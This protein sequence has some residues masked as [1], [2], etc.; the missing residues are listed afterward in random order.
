MNR[1]R[2]SLLAGGACA[3]AAVA[4]TAAAQEGRSRRVLHEELRPPP[5]QAARTAARLED[6]VPI[7][8][9]DP[10]PRQ[11]PSAVAARDKILPEPAAE[12]SPSA[13]E[14]VHGGDDFGAVRQNEAR[15]DYM[16]GADGTLHYVEVFNPSVV[17]FKR[18]SAL[19]SVREDYTLFAGSPA[20][21]DVAVGGAPSEDRD[22]FW[23][24]LVVELAPG[25]DVPIPSV[26][27]DMRILS[28]EVEPAT[29]VTFSR[30]GSDNFYVRSDETG[31]AGV[32][33]L[34][35]LAD[36]DPRYF[37]PTVPERLR[38]RDV[39]SDRVAPLPPRVRLTAERALRELGVDRGMRVSEALERLTY[40]FRDFSPKAP[41]RA[42]GDVY[43]DLFSSR[44][45]VC[46]HRS[47]AFMITAN[48]LGLPTRYLTNEAHAWVEVWLPEAGWMRVDLGGAAQTLQ[49]QNARDK[50]MY[51]PR[52]DDPFAKPPSYAE[53]Y[54]RLEGDVEGLSD[55][56]IAERQAPYAA[57][58][59]GDGAGDDAFEDAA[60]PAAD[61]SASGTPVAPGAG[62]PEVPEE[63]L[64]GKQ[65]TRTIVRTASSEGYRGESITIEG[66][67]LGDG[68][69]GLP[70]LRVD[71]FLAPAGARGEGARRIGHAVTASDG[72]F[73]ARVALPADLPL[74]DHEV[75]AS[76]PGDATY[77]P[78]LSD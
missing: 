9:P 78:S 60:E 76:T 50:A 45:G 4:L 27:P 73:V 66:E 2:L 24:S 54:T 17:P 35:F 53:N 22:L 6:G 14:P 15:P 21:A 12:P 8:G 74:D 67:V 71:V 62:L 3:A 56:Q 26:A 11:N 7:F 43:W 32:H 44:A 40:Y 39:P 42:S 69:R 18:M 30:D 37:A 70:S 16:T 19:D 59:P 75:F 46:R 48:A 41:P 10:A 77:Q 51:R 29:T 23:A 61:E 72:H 38:V 20:L 34:V 25:V 68:G 57:D 13:D 65:P 55:D 5:E 28:Y 49:V 64:A 63:E 36:A 58:Q 33:R 52:G 1:R 31:V 47:F